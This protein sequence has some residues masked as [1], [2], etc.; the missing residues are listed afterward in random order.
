[1]GPKVE[2]TGSS[3][4]TVD[5]ISSFRIHLPKPV[6]DTTKPSDNNVCGIENDPQKVDTAT[7][8]NDFMMHQ[9]TGTEE[10][11]ITSSSD[12]NRDVHEYVFI[13]IKILFLV[14]IYFSCTQLGPVHIFLYMLYSYSH[15]YLRLDFANTIN[16]LIYVLI[17]SSRNFY[18]YKISL[19]EGLYIM[20]QP[21]SKIDLSFGMH[22]VL[23]DFT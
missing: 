2:T 6:A 12:P 18:W 5:I 19:V 16:L 4:S 15:F 9:T 22:N 10:L 20:K 14:H 1:M 11:T 7:S 21:T 23:I 3:L 17:A 13:S 8:Y